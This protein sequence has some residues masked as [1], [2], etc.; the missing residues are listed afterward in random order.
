[1]NEL[2]SAAPT[3]SDTGLR[4]PLWRS[5]ALLLL[6]LLAG[7]ST[8]FYT[9]YVLKPLQI[10]DARV[11]DRPRGN[12][13]DLY[14]RWLGTREL[15]LNGRNPYS[16]QITLE[17]QKGYYGRELD[18]AKP[19]DP[20][21]QQAFAY[22]VYVIFLLGPLIVLPFHMAQMLMYWMLVALMAAS[23][24][25]WLSILR[26]RVSC[27]G[28][29]SC[30]ALTLGSF[31]AVQG[32]KLQQL[33]LL[34]AGLLTIAVYCIRRRWNFAGGAI[35]AVATI[36]PQL[37][38]LLV[39][40]ILLWAVSEWKS[41]RNV[42]L[43]FA[44]VMLAFLIGAEWVLPGWFGMFLH[45]LKDYRQYTD[46]LSVLDELVGTGAGRTLAALAVVLALVVL[47]PARRQDRES[48]AFPGSVCLV[49]ALTILVAPMFS[50]YNQVLLLGP[51]LWLAWQVGSLWKHSRA[52]R[53]VIAACTLAIV[54]PWMATLALT[55]AK[56][57][58]Q[59]KI[60]Q[61]W[62]SPL[63][64]TFSIPILVYTAILLGTVCARNEFSSR[65]RRDSVAES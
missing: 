4:V 34:V 42:I 19:Y 14:P 54:W 31:P 6:T 32:F 51:V 60:L 53:A 48:L 43:G 59:E 62:R 24:P 8:W 58:F 10:A 16:R 23:V 7:A 35:L 37:S 50:P 63:Y 56:L 33:T 18:R 17:I 1:M 44:T 28:V 45:A 47:W 26:W 15:L 9:D 55:A 11:H 2:V 40:W 36:K 5:V 49:L 13:S 38:W 39:G 27:I 65:Q 64:S 61:F 52:Y 41:R 46:S 12:L 25:L 3:V 21:D 57:G 20:K 29:L 30:I 22:P